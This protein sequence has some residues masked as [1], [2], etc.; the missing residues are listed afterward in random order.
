MKRIDSFQE[1]GT[2]IITKRDDGY[3]PC[4][5]LHLKKFR[6]FFIIEKYIPNLSTKYFSNHQNY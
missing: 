2:T 6:F 4:R 3:E 5:H 1:E